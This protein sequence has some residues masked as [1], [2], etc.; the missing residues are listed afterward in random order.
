MTQGFKPNTEDAR[1]RLLLFTIN[2]PRQ[3]LPLFPCQYTVALNANS[4]GSLSLVR[5]S[6]DWAPVADSGAPNRAISLSDK[7]QVGVLYSEPRECGVGGGRE[8]CCGT[9]TKD[10]R[11]F[12]KEEATGITY[13]AERICGDYVKQT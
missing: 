5:L 6:S 1:D 13:I 11:L 8:G 4:D 2:T 10:V 7:A 9:L 12:Q 3:S